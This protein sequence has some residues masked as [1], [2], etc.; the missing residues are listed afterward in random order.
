MI[1]LI[2]HQIGCQGA[3]DKSNYFNNFRNKALHIKDL[4]VFCAML[5][6][7]QIQNYAIIESLEINFPEGMTVIT[8]ETGKAG[9]SIF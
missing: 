5:K 2:I 3:V 8:G 1:L 4:T 7:I 6:H 9:K